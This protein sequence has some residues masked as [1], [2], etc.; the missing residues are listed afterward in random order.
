[1]EWEAVYP[2]FFCPVRQDRGKAR[3]ADRIRIFFII[4]GARMNGFNGTN[5]G[6]GSAVGA[7]FR[8]NFVNITFRDGFNRTFINTGATCSTIVSD[9]V[10][11][12]ITFY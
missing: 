1:M 8:V 11:H 5:I 2:A 7:E 6:T 12:D 9:Y 10:C 3:P 4:S